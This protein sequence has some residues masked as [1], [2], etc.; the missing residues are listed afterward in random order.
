LSD[1]RPLKDNHVQPSDAPAP[2]S[3]E[4]QKARDMVEIARDLIARTHQVLDTIRQLVKRKEEILQYNQARRERQAEQMAAHATTV[5]HEA[6][7]D[8][9]TERGAPE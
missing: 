4:I 6:G 9:G 3:E 1:T 7:I 5:P 8:I 2:P